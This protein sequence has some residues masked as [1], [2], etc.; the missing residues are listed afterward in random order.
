MCVCRRVRA[1]VR[2][3]VVVMRRRGEKWAVVSDARLVVFRHRLEGVFIA[4]ETAQPDRE[5][6]EESPG[7]GGRG[8]RQPDTASR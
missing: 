4:A 7:R 3:V 8:G 2:T 1:C 5:E 6:R